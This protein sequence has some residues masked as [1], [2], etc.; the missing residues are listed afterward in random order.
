MKR[1]NHSVS[2]VHE[3]AV[4]FFSSLNYNVS[5]STDN[6]LVFSGGKDLN[7]IIFIILLCLGILLGLV[8][9]LL[10]K[11]KTVTLTFKT[12]KGKTIVNAVG[13]CEEA[14][15]DGQKFLDSL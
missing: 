7:W 1:V 14:R 4:A 2:E 12:Q 10:A 15:K 6:M 9:Y 8:Y 3:K 5:S 11:E 13:S